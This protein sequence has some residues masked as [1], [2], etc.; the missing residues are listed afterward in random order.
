MPV[1]VLVSPI[2]PR[3]TD[4]DVPRII[5]QAAAAGARSI[6]YTALRLPGSV[7]PVF[8][9]RLREAMPLRADRVLNRLRDI[10]GGRLS[11]SRFGERMRGHGPYWESIR[12]LFEIS[13][14]RYGFADAA[15]SQCAQCIADRTCERPA[16]I[17]GQLVFDFD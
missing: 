9:K 2:I 15:E 14:K 6:S 5:Q 12:N 16:Q 8:I 7:E 3:L 4:R 13:R 10:R 1:G 11:D 17:D